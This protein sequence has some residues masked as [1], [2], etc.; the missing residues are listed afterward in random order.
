MI[1]LLGPDGTGKSVLAQRLSTLT[2]LRVVH[3]TKDSKYEDYLEVLVNVDEE[4]ICDRFIWC[5]IPY[6]QTRRTSDNQLQFT[7]KQL[8]NATLLGLMR[9]PLVVLCTHKP[10]SYDEAVLPMEN[11]DRCLSIYRE[12]LVQQWIPWLHYD[13]SS[14]YPSVSAAGV[15]ILYWQMVS[16]D[17]WWK[18]MWEAGWG[19]VGSRHPDVL[20]VAE[21]IGP[22]NINN[23]PFETGPTG[24]MLSEVLEKTK[25]PL[26]KIAI[27]NMVKD[28]RRA[29]RPPSPQDME[30]FRREIEHLC[31]RGILFMGKIAQAGIKIADE[32]EVPYA[33]I[34]HLGFLHHSGIRDLGPY[35]DHW[36]KLWNK[37]AGIEENVKEEE[38]WKSQLI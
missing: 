3:F 26:G 25:M 33:T 24:Y 1:I 38:A 22:N 14:P 9:N 10:V 8:H 2:E 6:S 4:V 18:P 29:T 17:D 31:P 11:W 34:D 19:A 7:L 21:R 20:V 32:Y 13:Y 5:E 16:S 28:A 36:T 15:A 23:I 37:L 30:Y 12:F 27:T 35:C